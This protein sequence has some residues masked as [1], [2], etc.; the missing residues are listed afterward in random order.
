[1][2]MTCLLVFTWH[3]VTRPFR[4]LKANILEAVSLACLV[5]IATINLIQAIFLS[6]GVAPQGSVE[7]DLIVLH[8][9]EIC[10]LAIAP[11]LLVF[12][13]GF[14]VVSQVARVAVIVFRKTFRL[15]LMRRIQVM[16][17]Y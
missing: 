9:A 1:M 3:V 12:L 5:V 13:C 10:L 14:A 7:R 17:Q 6:A 16:G 2:D 4:D 8:K 11:L 15:V